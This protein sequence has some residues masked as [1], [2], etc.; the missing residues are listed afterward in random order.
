[1]GRTA[2]PAPPM[3][4][5]PINWQ[6]TMITPQDFHLEDYTVEP[7]APPMDDSDEEMI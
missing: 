6:P 2:K 5:L 7:S 3:P 4:Q 1:M